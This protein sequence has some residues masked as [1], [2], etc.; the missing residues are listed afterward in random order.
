MRY[1]FFIFLFV[2]ALYS[3]SSP[4]PRAPITV[5]KSTVLQETVSEFKKLNKI[6]E[7]KIKMYIQKD[8]AFN[9]LLSSNGYWYAVL[10][11]GDTLKTVPKSEDIVTFSQEIYNLNDQLIYAKS[12][13][14][15]RIYKVDKEDLISALQH[16]IKKMHVGATY[17]FVI[18]SYSAYG[19]SGDQNKI[20]INQSIINIVTLKNIK[21]D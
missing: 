19:L 20:G 17:K 5:K 14:K 1:S 21:E 10:E 6:E 2:F 16:G 4:E 15:D 12:E 3:C 7:E 9:Y 13:L 18:P 8:S 11:K